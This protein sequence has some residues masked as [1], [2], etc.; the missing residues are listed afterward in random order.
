MPAFFFISGLFHNNHRV[1]EKVCTYLIL[2]L[3][4]KVVILLEKIL[5]GMNADFSLFTEKGIP[6]FLLTSAVFITLTYV[7]KNIYRRFLLF[8]SVFTACMAGYDPSIGDT[9]SLSRILVFYPFYLG[10]SCVKKESIEALR[11]RRALQAAA[12]GILLLWAGI[13]LFKTDTVYLLR[14]LFTGRNPFNSIELSPGPFWRLLCYLIS[15]IMIF[16]WLLISPGK[17]FPLTIWGRRT[18]QVYFWHRPIL[19][20]LEYWDLPKYCDTLQLQLLWILSGVLLAILLSQ[21]P[22]GFLT[23]AVSRAVHGDNITI[24]DDKIHPSCPISSEIK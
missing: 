16:S 18:L 3:L 2:Y 23:D 11:S 24:T 5:L 1:R 14:P 8:F 9:F 15:C 13:C 4:L 19:Y 7:L 22:F 20:L 17:T 21:K 10:G 6:W 12:V